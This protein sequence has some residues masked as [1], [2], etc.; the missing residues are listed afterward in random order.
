[1]PADA[2][3]K[4]EDICESN[5][6]IIIGEISKMSPVFHTKPWDLIYTDIDCAFPR[7]MNIR[8]SDMGV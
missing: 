2:Y 3:A 4:K 8:K 6:W 1:M 7:F 5:H